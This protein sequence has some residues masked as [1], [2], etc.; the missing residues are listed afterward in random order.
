M[1]KYLGNKYQNNKLILSFDIKHENR[2]MQESFVFFGRAI[3]LGDVP[4]VNEPN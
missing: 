1:N 2:A 3:C 4:E